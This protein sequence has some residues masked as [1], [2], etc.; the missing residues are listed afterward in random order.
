MCASVR[1]GFLGWLL[2]VRVVLEDDIARA[3]FIEVQGDGVQLCVSIKGIFV[4][5]GADDFEPLANPRLDVR[6]ERMVED[7]EAYDV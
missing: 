3:L 1:G 4:Y 7:F 5:T 2:F 6:A